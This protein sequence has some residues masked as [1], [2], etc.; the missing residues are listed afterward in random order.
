[1]RVCGWE[2]LNDLQRPWQNDPG[3]GSVRSLGPTYTGARLL[4]L[5]NL[6]DVMALVHNQEASARHLRFGGYGTLGFCIGSSGL[7]LQA[8]EGDCPLFP[9]L[10][11]GIWR[12]RLDRRA[13]HLQKNAVLRADHQ[14]S[15]ELYRQ[16]L[17]HLPLD[18][19]LHGAA[20]QAASHRLKACQPGN[21]PFRLVQQFSG[22]QPRPTSSSA[23]T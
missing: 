22:I 17:Q 14:Q 6:C 3:N 21:S 7:L 15:L 10:L 9:I 4:E 13:S 12:E 20:A 18:L 19:S 1:M 16:A 11:G 23:T 8:M 5:L 2:P